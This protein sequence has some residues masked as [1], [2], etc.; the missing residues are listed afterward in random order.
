MKKNEIS[1]R[2]LE[3]SWRISTLGILAIL[4]LALALPGFSKDDDIRLKEEK[5]RVL[6]HLLLVDS[7]NNKDFQQAFQMRLESSV[8]TL[9]MSKKNKEAFLQA[10]RKACSEITPEDLKEL[11][12]RTYAETYT[13]FEIEAMIKFYSSDEGRQIIQ[14]QKD[15]KRAEEVYRKELFSKIIEQTRKHLEAGD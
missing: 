4:W 9:P 10:A 15:F 5:S 12:V 11:T 3:T 13:I 1:D 8:E 6:V 14:K 2:S 7:G